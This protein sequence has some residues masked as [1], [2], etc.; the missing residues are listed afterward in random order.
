MQ[1][2]RKREKRVFRITKF[3][4]CNEISVRGTRRMEIYKSQMG[5]MQL[6]GTHWCWERQ[7]RVITIIITIVLPSASRNESLNLLHYRMSCSNWRPIKL[8]SSS[9]LSHLAYSA[10]YTFRILTILCRVWGTGDQDA[11]L[12]A[13]WASPTITF[14]PDF[15]KYIRWWLKRNCF[16]S[17][18]VTTSYGWL[19]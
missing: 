3:R 16:E 10:L 4:N 2:N 8:V 6:N 11:A 18:M 9:C 14:G 15:P 7:R 12:V 17:G 5:A 13:L 1:C 19:N